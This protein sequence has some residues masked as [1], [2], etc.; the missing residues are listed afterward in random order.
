MELL[1]HEIPARILDW[2]A[3]LEILLIAS[4]LYFL[5]RNLSAMGAWKIV[6]GI[7]IGLGVFAVARL[8]GLTGIE[9]VLSHFSGVALIALIV[10]FQPEIRRLFE[11]A[12][13]FRR[14]GHRAERPGLTALLTDALFDLARR[15]WGAIVV[16]PGRE[17]LT[18]WTSRGIALDA[19][20]SFPLLIS[21]FDPS[22]PGHDG[23]TV[24]ENEKLTA[25]GVR[26]P[27]SAR[28]KL[29]SHLGTRHH[30]ALGLSEVTDALVLVV[31]EER[32]T[33]S[34]FVAG[35][36]HEI[37]S[38]EQLAKAV[39]DQWQR[40]LGGTAPGGAAAG[41][42][43]L[44]VPLFGSLLVATLF[45]LSIV[46]HRGEQ[47]EMTFQVPV[48]YAA[49]P[50]LSPVGERVDQAR[51]LVAGATDDLSKVDPSLLR[52]RV[53]LSAVEAGRQLIPLKLGGA[54][55]P[56]GVRLVGIEPPSL[57]LDLRPLVERHLPVRAQ[58]VGAP[59]PRSRVDQVEVQPPSLKVLVPEGAPDLP[60]EILTEPIRLTGVSGP[61]RVIS[62]VVAPSGIRPAGGSWP[63]VE[64]RLAVLPSEGQ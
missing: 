35:K 55:L 10:L 45:W 5:Y 1:W 57:A 44:S 64:V 22:S 51:I 33:I 12:V 8:L 32:Q 3:P 27:L 38:K 31:S 18:S 59:P 43:I 17:S 61:T 53:D 50:D 49:A 34:A 2:R 42:R 24:I 54:E 48:E 41:H 62:R 58:L 14:A 60:E 47:L 6:M 7:L 63:D 30:A 23:A 28:G 11:R 26:L 52:V 13:S 15:K 19:T 46:P 36:R 39:D 9:W 29:P 25:F 16:I 20:P 56:R 40:T 4:G 21:I 37:G